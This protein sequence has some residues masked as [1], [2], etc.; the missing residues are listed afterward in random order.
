ML[1]R[2]H[3]LR[4]VAVS[5]A[6]AFVPAV[7]ANSPVRLIVPF[8]PGGGGDTIARSLVDTFKRLLSRDVWVDNRP[9]A[10]GSLGTNAVV[11]AKDATIGYVTNGIL[12]VNQHLYPLRFNPLA[13]LKPVGQI[14]RIGL[15]VTINPKVLPGVTDLKSLIAYAK[16]HPGKVN[17]ASSG[18]GTTSH[19]AGKCLERAADI[20]LVHIPYRGGAAAMLDVLSGRIGLMIDVAPNALPHVQ[21]GRLKALAV[22]TEARLAQAPNIP[23]AAELGLPELTLYA[24]DGFVAPVG[25]TDAQ[26]E[27]LNRA[28]QATLRDP[29]VRKKLIDKGAEPR[30]CDAAAF[31]EFIRNEAVKWKTLVDSI[32]SIRH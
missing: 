17:F 8:P 1:S 30:P 32:D 19:L 15:V 25:T 28:L 31:A 11:Q 12:C 27:T 13:D 3:L 20:S 22:T 5:V 16:A 23:T 26:I 21:S 10:G 14:S 9:G 2:R 24:W 4:A 6:A 7:R 29:E 18:N